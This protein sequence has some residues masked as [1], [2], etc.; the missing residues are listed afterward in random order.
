MLP[1]ASVFLSEMHAM[2]Q[3]LSYLILMLLPILFSTVTY[4]RTSEGTDAEM[5]ELY[6]EMAKKH[7]NN[8]QFSKAIDLNKK[9]LE[10][11]MKTEDS[12][13]AA[14]TGLKLAKLTYKKVRY[15]ESLQYALNSLEY[16]ERI[17][18]KKN[19]LDLQNLLSAIYF[20]CKDKKT[21]DMYV[22]QSL[23]GAQNIHD[24]AAMVIAFNN[25]AI[26]NSV[27]DTEIS[28]YCLSE[29]IRL[30]YMSG[31]TLHLCKILQNGCSIS[32]HNGDLKTAREYIDKSYPYISESNIELSGDYYYNKARIEFME[33]E[34]YAAIKSLE[35]AV[36]F[37]KL[38]EFDTSL[39]DCYMM[40]NEAFR[41]AGKISDA[42][43]ALSE[44]Y[45][46][47]STLSKEN[48]FVELLRYKNDLMMEEEQKA[49]IKKRG[50]QLL[51]SSILVSSLLIIL[52][53]AY[54]LMRRKNEILARQ[55]LINEKQEQEIASKNE[56]IELKKLRQYQ[57]QC[58]TEEISEKLS[59]LRQ[60]TK[61]E[62]IRKKLMQISNEICAARESG[63]KE[64]SVYMPEMNKEM[65]S[66]LL[67]DFPNLTVNERRLCCF[68][69]MNMTTKEIA[70]ITRKNIQS[71]NTAR[72]RLRT[73]LGLTGSDIS[74]QEFL[75]KYN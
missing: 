57:I 60:E 28:Q 67:K 47:D 75:S 17:G 55:K 6:T 48:M 39:Q 36:S 56:I 71:I 31:D 41:K 25:M 21:S 70:E 44:Y 11:Y 13:G 52:L 64:I 61:D 37:Y 54:I 51:L 23:T 12:Y 15:D 72:S 27:S 42:Y 29:A 30:A 68:L 50:A 33:N 65:F 19:T 16:F 20:M 9:A 34:T 22:Q 49:A 43:K 46:I 5:A 35:K 62:K 63:L 74:V 3:I 58:L 59:S 40:M 10:H 32:I 45:R 8:L 73:K 38:G 14:V 53:M 66:K 7:E 24:T 69:N 4:A 2:K 26:Y 1:E 18:D